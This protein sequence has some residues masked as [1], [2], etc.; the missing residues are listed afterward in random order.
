MSLEKIFNSKSFAK[1]G[2]VVCLLGTVSA[3]AAAA[4]GDNAFFSCTIAFLSALGC[5][6]FG[7]TLGKLEAGDSLKKSAS[8]PTNF[9]EPPIDGPKS[10]PS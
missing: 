4:R 6:S 2:V 1:V 9:D 8:Q 3:A 10:G 5:G 7:H